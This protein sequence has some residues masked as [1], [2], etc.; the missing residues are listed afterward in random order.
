M[1]WEDKNGATRLYLLRHGE[2]DEQAQKICYGQLDVGLSELGKEQSRELANRLASES[3]GALY[4]SDLIR[5]R[6]LAECL[7]EVH[8]L[9][10]GV[11]PLLR[12]RSYGVWQGVEFE[13]LYKDRAEEVQAY[14]STPDYL[15]PGGE[16]FSMLRLR[17]KPW[18]DEILRQHTGQSIA[19]TTHG[20]VTRLILS[21]AMGIPLE[22]IYSF[23]QKYCCL[24]IIDYFEGRC[25]VQLV[26]G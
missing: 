10:P 17:V 21:E 26:N 25:R 23:E 2:V 24:N 18:L 16:N 11:T 8:G 14:L 13:V 5:A 1:V 19:V 20:G 3:I 12:E 6:Y 15:V 7:E 22:K 9:S 4:S